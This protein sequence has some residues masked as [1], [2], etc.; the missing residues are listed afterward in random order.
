MSTNDVCVSASLLPTGLVVPNPARGG[1]IYG[2][3]TFD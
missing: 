3:I 1:E 2:I